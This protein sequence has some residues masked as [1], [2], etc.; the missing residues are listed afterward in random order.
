MR[1]DT[2]PSPGRLSMGINIRTIMAKAISALELQA[3][4]TGKATE[5]AQF[6]TFLV[7]SRAAIAAFID[8]VAPTAIAYFIKSAEASK[9][10]VQLSEG[11]DPKFVPPASAFVI[12]GTAKVVSKVEV[13]GPFLILTVTVPFV[14]GNA[15]T[16]AYTQP[17]GIGNARDLSGN[18]L[19]SFTAQAIVN[20]VA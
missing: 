15:A 18:L 16:V 12:A 2:L 8:V 20:N 19:A 13:D 10:Y 6:D 11:V 14:N 7:A 3:T 9:V 4:Y 1:V 5:A 17:G